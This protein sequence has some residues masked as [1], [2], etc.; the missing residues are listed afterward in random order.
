MEFKIIRVR[1]CSWTPTRDKDRTRRSTQQ[2]VGTVT[3]NNCLDKATI[4]QEQKKD[5]FCTKNNTASY[6]SNSDFFLDNEGAMYRRQQ[7]GKHQL[8]VPETQIEEVIRENHDPIFVAH[9][10]IQRTYRL[11]S[12]EIDIFRKPTT[13]DTPSA[14]CP[15]THK[16]VHIAYRLKTKC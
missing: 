12:L 5:A 6:S 1:L 14:I 7:N 8:V 9:P 3:V 2:N 13:T 11:V 4:L 16:T 10:G 15:T